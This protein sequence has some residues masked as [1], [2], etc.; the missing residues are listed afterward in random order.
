MGLRGPKPDPS[1]PNSRT[2]SKGNRRI[3]STAYNAAQVR[4]LEPGE[5]AKPKYVTGRAGE[6]WDETVKLLVKAKLIAEVDI[7][8]LGAYCLDMSTFVDLSIEL[9]EA[10]VAD[11]KS[12]KKYSESELKGL[13]EEANQAWGRAKQLGDALG[14]SSKARTGMG[15]TSAAPGD[16]AA[17]KGGGIASGSSNLAFV[18]TGQR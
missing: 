5:P 17:A 3:G 2:K 1:R 14:M 18:L 16:H 7:H 10:R 6:I 8:T 15:I 13:R 9:K 11:N 4:H 12:K